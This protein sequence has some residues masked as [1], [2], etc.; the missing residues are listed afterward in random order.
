MFDLADR[1]AQQ[2][3]AKQGQAILFITNTEEV[4]EGEIT[5]P[6]TLIYSLI[7][8]CCCLFSLT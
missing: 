2:I 1:Q 3:S 4:E 5:Q 7:H 6:L 8:F